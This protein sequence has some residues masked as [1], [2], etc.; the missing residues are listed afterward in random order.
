MKKL[1]LLIFVMIILLFSNSLT[2][3]GR[4]DS[5]TV[6]DDISKMTSE[7]IVAEM[8]YAVSIGQGG[9]YFPQDRIH[10]LEKQMAKNQTKEIDRFKKE[11]DRDAK[12]AKQVESLK[13]KAVDKAKEQGEKYYKEN[14]AKIKEQVEEQARKAMKMSKDQWNANKSKFNNMYKNGSDAYTKHAEKYVEVAKTA[15]EAY[16]AYASA[17]KNHPE[18]PDSAQN[19]IG[20]LNATGVALKF[21]GDKMDKTPLRPIGEILKMYAAATSLGDT[22]GKAAWNAI[23]HEGINPNFKTKYTK[24]L[25]KVGIGAFDWAGIEK[26]S[27][28]MHNKDIRILKL[29]DGYVVFNEN[30]EVI[31][32]GS[33]NILSKAEYKKLEELYVGFSTG[34]KEG[35]PDLTA[36]QLAKLVR[37]DKIKVNLTNNFLFPDSI[38]EFDS[39]NIEAMGESQAER[40]I[41]DDIVTSLDRIINGEQGVLDKLVDPFTRY[42]RQ[43]E[44]RDL[45]YEF[46]RQGD[47]FDSSIHRKEAFLEWVNEIKAENDELTPKEL[48]ELL[49]NLLDEGKEGED[50]ED[51]KDKDKE[52]V[53]PEEPTDTE[54]P[55]DTEDPDENKDPLTEELE[56]IDPDVENADASG[57]KTKEDQPE[58]ASDGEDHWTE[59]TPED[60]DGSKDGGFTNTGGTNRPM[61]GGNNPQAIGIPVLKPNI[62]LYPESPQ[63]ITVAFK[64]PWQLTTVIPD[65]V[66]QWKVLV[67]PKGTI[68][69]TYGFL[70][71]E[72]TVGKGFF[73]KTEGWQLPIGNRDKS[74]DE[75]LDLYKF[76]EQ[77][78]EDFIEFWTEKLDETTEYLIYPQETKII[79]A[80]MPVDVTPVPA[81]AYRI[82]FYFIPDDGT[83]ILEP[84][85]VE[86]IDRQG[87]TLVEW[88]GMY[89]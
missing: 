62:Y 13:Q 32:G 20:F 79:D 30:F 84:E 83:L 3:S 33:G 37:G 65:Y 43:K 87:F 47:V 53:D 22:A 9:K 18:A 78:K 8:K 68:D 74:F 76:N 67:E 52:E 57:V 21:A 26:S 66:N 55:A 24:G 85:S 17:K 5:K 89:E 28:M 61:P 41:G 12:V 11:L 77:E 72:A 49:K 59:Q 1:N 7:E 36:E 4:Y 73:Q 10:E 42:T 25:D 71:Y 82:W 54:D 39:K 14:E 6:F 40:T 60:F 81:S 23:H 44:L 86:E 45:M 58:D 16:E 38:K 63:V 35:W 46:M 34:K 69:D 27:L 70:F 64:Y 2:A 75:L 31:P 88:G 29:A 19:L 80:V 56:K 48:K 50:G 51:E 15:Y